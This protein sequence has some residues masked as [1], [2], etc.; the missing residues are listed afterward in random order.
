MAP[1]TTLCWPLLEMSKRNVKLLGDSAVTALPSGVQAGEW[2]VTGTNLLEGKSTK[3][4]K[5][6]PQWPPQ[7]SPGPAHLWVVQDNDFSVGGLQLLLPFTQGHSNHVSFL[8]NTTPSVSQLE[9][10]P[11]LFNPWDVPHPAFRISYQHFAKEG[12]KSAGGAAG[13]SQDLLLR[14]L[15]NSTL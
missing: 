3:R 13:S 6:T 7:R 2:D 5:G 12:E 4:A 9:V 10:C 8:Q 1:H 11:S 14:V 15:K